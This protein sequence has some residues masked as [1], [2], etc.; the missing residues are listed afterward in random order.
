MPSQPL[1]NVDEL[2]VTDKRQSASPS[3]VK[4][5]IRE[6]LNTSG[7]NDNVLDDLPKIS[8]HF[9]KISE[10]FQTCSEGQTNV[11]EYFPKI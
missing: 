3:C 7:T 9:P 5:T 6:A 11:S 1:F 8:D 2:F 10:D 4:G